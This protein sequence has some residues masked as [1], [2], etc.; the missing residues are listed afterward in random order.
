MQKRSEIV[1]VLS[2]IDYFNG[3]CCVSLSKWRLLKTKKAKKL[4]ENLFFSVYTYRNSICWLVMHTKFWN[5]CTMTNQKLMFSFNGLNDMYSFFPRR[6]NRK[7]QLHVLRRNIKRKILKISQKNWNRTKRL[8]INWT[9]GRR[10][11]SR[12]NKFLIEMVNIF[13]SYTNWLFRFL[14]LDLVRLAFTNTTI[15]PKNDFNFALRWMKMKNV[16]FFAQKSNHQQVGKVFHFLC[17]KACVNNF[18]AF[19]ILAIAK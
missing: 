15:R 17:C 18:C 11:A 5:F 13:L 16:I 14:I 3:I 9:I 6:D 8:K 12:K 2:K 7:K 1:L 19:L 10:T 4:L